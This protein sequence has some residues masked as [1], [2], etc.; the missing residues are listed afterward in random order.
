M[1][2]ISCREASGLRVA[3]KLQGTNPFMKAGSHQ[4]PLVTARSKTKFLKRN[5]CLNSLLMTHDRFSSE[6]P[7]HIVEMEVE[8][9]LKGVRIDTFLSRHLRN[10]TQFRLQ[11][12]VRAGV[13]EI[14]GEQAELKSRVRHGQHVRI[15]LI[16][17]PDKLLQPEPIELDVLQRDEWTIAVNKPPGMIVHPVGIYDSGT[18]VNALQHHLDVESGVRGL[19]RPGIVHRLDRM[20]SGV[21]VTTQH[22]LSHRML[23]IQFQENRISKTYQALVEGVVL[24]DHG[25]IE[26]PIGNVPRRDSI[27]MTAKADAIDRKP[28]R[29]S[30]T[31]LQRFRD[32]TLVQCRPK[33]GR[34]HQIRV[35]LAEIGHPVVGDEYYGAFGRIKQ[36]PHFGL[37]SAEFPGSQLPEWFPDVP[38]PPQRHLLHA[39]RIEFAHPISLE[40]MAIEAPLTSDF[41]AVVDALAES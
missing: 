28:A 20:T 9:Y 23:S 6:L 26:L 3:K 18:L 10:Y 41:Q 8:K 7:G 36:P 22:H 39:E 33:T 24:K 32:A 31:V 12:M 21:I 4:W 35:H 17:P 2:T 16:D 15:R 27:L 14:A 34:F 30:F 13:V 5:S 11:R 40:W 37:P 38:M 29:T 1:D 19:Q 25:V